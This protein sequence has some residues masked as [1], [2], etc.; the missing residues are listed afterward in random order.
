MYRDRYM[1]KGWG[2]DRVKGK[3]KV[4]GSNRDTR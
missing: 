2:K 1:G 3:E 4:K